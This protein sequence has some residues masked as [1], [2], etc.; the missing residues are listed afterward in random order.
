MTQ[1]Q[2]VSDMGTHYYREVRHWRTGEPTGRRQRVQRYLCLGGPRN[3]VWRSADELINAGMI[4]EY[5]RYNA[6]GGRRGK[7]DHSMVF[8]HQDLLK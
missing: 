7:N 8:L 3:G 1:G 5:H 2:I 6:G 4:G